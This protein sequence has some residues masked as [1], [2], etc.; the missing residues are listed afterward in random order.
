MPTHASS[1]FTP[2]TWDEETSSEVDGRLKI[3]HA[4]VTFGYSG[5]LEGESAMQYLMLYRDD[6]SAAVIGLERVTGK[7]CGKPGTFVLQHQGGYADNTASG[8]FDVV[9]GSASGQLAGL[10]GHGT[11]V[12]RKDGTTAFSF[13]FDLPA[14]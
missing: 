11:A 7:L 8:E 9:E 13:D 1:T 12:A 6:G 3:T 5:D 4:R 2:K 10:R 14:Q